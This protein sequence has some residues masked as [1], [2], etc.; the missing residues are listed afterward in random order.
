VSNDRWEIRILGP[1]ELARAGDEPRR[2]PRAKERALLGAL[3]LEPGRVVPTDELVDA[4]WGEEPPASAGNALQ[5]HVSNV[6]K[7]FDDDG[8]AVLRREPTGYALACAVD[9]AEFEDA[10]RRAA[11]ELAAG[12]HE[13]A[14]A[15]LRGAV[16]LWRGAPLEDTPLS[17]DR[18]LLLGRLDDLRRGSLEDL[19]TAELALGRHRELLPELERWV[20]ES[21]L[22]EPFREQLMLALYRSGRQQEALELYRETREYFLD[23]IGLEPG[24]ALRELE[25][26]ILNQ[27]P[28]L[29]PTAEP[30]ARQRRRL[31]IVAQS[32]VELDDEDDDEE[33]HERLADVVERVSDVYREAG[34]RVDT[35]PQGV[36]ALFGFP[37]IRED[38]PAR[39]AAAALAAGAEGVRTGV[40][41]GTAVAGDAHALRLSR[42]SRRALELA[43]AAGAGEVLVDADLQARLGTGAMLQRAGDGEA[44]ELFAAMPGARPLSA[45]PLVGREAELAWLREAVDDAAAALVVGE[46]GIGKTRLATEARAAIAETSRVLY[47]RCRDRVGDPYAPLREALG[48]AFEAEPPAEVAAAVARAVGDRPTAL[49]FDDVHWAEPLFV[50]VLELL[51]AALES[52]PVATIAF[53]RAEGPELPW[54][55]LALHALD[56]TETQALLVGLGEEPALAARLA[57]QVH[58]RAAGNPLFVEQLLASGD[59]EAVPPSLEALLHARLD[60]VPAGERRVLEAAAVVDA[61]VDSQLLRRL[62]P[63]ARNVDACVDALRRRRLL[64]GD[65]G[66]VAFAHQ[67]IRDAAY[68]T[69]PR[70]ERATLHERLATLLEER[71]S[72]ST[73]LAHHLDAAYGAADG[74]T[75]AELAPR[76][77]HHLE[78]AGRTA[79]ARGDNASARRLL[80]RAAALA[81]GAGRAELLALLGDV[82]REAGSFDAAFAAFDE[83]SAATD[84]EAFRARIEV[85]RMRVENSSWRSVD[86]DEQRQRLEVAIATLERAGD[87]RSLAEAWLV[88]SR[89]DWFQCRAAETEVAALHGLEHARAAGERR[90]AGA[91]RIEN[92][93]LYQWVGALLYGPTPV[94]TA[95]AE[96]EALIADEATSERVRIGANM[97]LAALRAMECRF[98]EA[99]SLLD[100]DEE[101][102]AQLAVKGVD[103]GRAA[104]AAWVELEAGEPEAAA[105]VLRQAIEPLE[106]IGE[107]AL[108]PTL[109]AVLADALR[110]S[111]DVEGA[112]AAVEIAAREGSPVDRDTQVQ[113]RTVSALLGGPDA[114]LH[115]REAVE[116]AEP[117]DFPNLRGGA[118]LALAAASPAKAES[119]L[120]AARAEYE[121]KGNRAALRRFSAR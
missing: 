22:H 2:V 96:C 25:R 72:D 100:Q 99:R 114:E 8:H 105:V 35:H 48:E 95:A 23:T 115:A 53:S 44:F 46:P 60:L 17:G 121:A 5:V 102:G 6:R 108:R 98:D 1:L 76:A 65:D 88:R 32:V 77:A 24:D 90:L 113:W 58:A 27:E 107:T 89:I 56:T 39:A 47:G 92:Q 11:D 91:R 50:E 75:A 28:A 45:S 118:F 83:A 104:I 36:L 74:E 93:C 109:Y 78:R 57:A 59:V 29:G 30:P 85:Q 4:L 73:T 63:E 33:L 120:P 12:R 101:L 54:R 106:A 62:L 67:L 66:T 51:P 71:G 18:E 37:T 19:A 43:A 110:R 10:A 82:L 31:V 38:D 40:A 81:T 9:L 116:L 112:R 42:P 3:A 55:R 86:H 49:F 87:D 26:G 52:L 13:R 80:E 34:A 111:G 7:L 79:Y 61:E 103:A 119:A 15:L 21:P 70:R 117:T 97:A 14:A 68:A 16:G 69:L 64:R 94:E 84:D 41:A 20:A